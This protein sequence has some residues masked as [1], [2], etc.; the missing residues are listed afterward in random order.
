MTSKPDIK[1]SYPMLTDEM[2][3]QLWDDSAGY[4]ALYDEARTFARNLIE[5]L[6]NNKSHLPNPKTPV[7]KD[8]ELEQST[9]RINGSLFRCSCGCNVF[10]KPDDTLLELYKCNA[11][12]V[13]YEAQ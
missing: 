11:C 4:Y 12:G 10:H 5:L 3:D 13:E 7:L 6:Q 1:A 9:I 2:I 8:G